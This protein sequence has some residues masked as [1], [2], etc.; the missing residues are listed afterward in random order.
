[1]TQSAIQIT[2]DRH[3]ADTLQ[4]RL[5]TFVRLAR[6]NGFRVGVAEEVDAQRVALHCDM[7]DPLRLRWGLR[8]L[9]CSSEDDWARYDGL[10]DAYWYNANRSIHTQ[11]SVGA[12]VKHDTKEGT[13]NKGSGSQAMEADQSLQGEAV[14]AVKEGVRKGAS[15]HEVLM[16]TD[17][18]FLSDSGE[19]RAV[20]RLAE[21]L[22]RKMRRRLVRRQTVL[23]HGRR[24]N[25][26]RTLRNSLR[27]GGMPLKLEYQQRM[28]RQPR[29]ILIVDVSRSMSMYSSV[30]LRFARGIVNAFR[31]ADAF[32]Y[33]THL[34]PISDAMRQSDLTQMRE[35]LALISQGWSGGTRIG[36][37]LESFNRHYAQRLN[38]RSVVMIVSDGLDTGEPQQLTKQLVLI[39]QR[40]RHL[41]WLN[42]LLGRDGYEPRTA[43]MQAALPL[44]DL[45]A[46][47]HNLE[48][49]QALESSLLKL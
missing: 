30:F 15:A 14:D 3:L 33:H 13:G 21:Q 40:A 34:V 31:D 27:F 4:G 32:A 8:S 37:C 16:K 47:A 26:R 38:S 29:L 49:L 18:Q 43:S 36:E 41:I 1:M 25:L 6:E 24:I 20:Q 22:A 2:T 17:F 11:S 35:S 10:F 23:R 44:I 39:K 7:T 48:S 9:L 19:M 5:V 45:F 28:R 42:P 12:P 46:P